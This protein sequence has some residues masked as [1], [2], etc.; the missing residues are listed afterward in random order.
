[1]IVPEI[2]PQDERSYGMYTTSSGLTCLLISDPTT[3]KASASM[4]V[5]VGQFNDPDHLPGKLQ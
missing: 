5:R 4:D 2:S 3:D 1:M